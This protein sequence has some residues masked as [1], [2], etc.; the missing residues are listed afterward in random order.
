MVAATERR[1]SGV[2]GVCRSGRRRPSR[3][4]A[5][6]ARA[7]S[8]RGSGR[9]IRFWVE[10]LEREEGVGEGDERHVVVP[11]PEGAS[12]EVVE[13]ERV[14]ELPVVVLDAPA[15]LREPHE[16]GERGGGGGGAGPGP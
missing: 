8:R 9:R 15:E 1:S 4:A 5:A 7:A 3:R 11:A 16:L 6:G 10:P 12:L 2:I 14:L 13:A